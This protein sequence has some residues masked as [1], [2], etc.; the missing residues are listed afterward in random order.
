ML[1]RTK[2]TKRL[3]SIKISKV[4]TLFNESI[5]RRDG[6]CVMAGGHNGNLECSHFFPV[7]GNGCL[8]F[9][10]PNAHTQCSSHH[11]GEFHNGNT[12][13][14]GRWMEVNVSQLEW[15]EDHR[16]TII[17]YSQPTLR[18]IADYCRRDCIYELTSFIE[19]LIQEA[20]A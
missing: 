6:M 12:L 13:P 3:S 9:Y 7:G 10:P 17:R 19:T 11:V 20:R 14:Y 2:R 4:Q 15:M 1:K 18:I 8:R 16:K 5:R